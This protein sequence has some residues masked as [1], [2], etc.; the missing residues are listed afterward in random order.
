MKKIEYL[1]LLLL[2]TSTDTILFG[3]NANQLFLYVPRILGLF[4]ILTIPHYSKICR[5]TNGRLTAICAFMLGCMALSSVLNGDEIVTT[6]SKAIALLTGYSIARNVNFKT[7]ANVLYKFLVF[8]AYIALGVELVSYIFPALIG[9]MPAIENGAGTV[10]RVFFIGSLPEGF[11]SESLI[12]SN[13]IFWEAGAFASYLIWVLMIQLFY[14]RVYNIKHVVILLLALLT[15]FSTTGYFAFIVLAIA[16]MLSGHTE[17]PSYQKMKKIFSVSSI[18]ILVCMVWFG[19]DS[20]F[21]LVFGKLGD[22]EDMD[23]SAQVRFSSFFNGI[24]AFRLNPF[25]G[26]GSNTEEIMKIVMNSGNVKYGGGGLLLTNTFIANYVCFGMFFGSLFLIGSIKF[27]NFFTQKRFS[28]IF[29]SLAFL[30]AYSGERFFSFIP[31]VFMFYGF[32]YIN[33]N[34]KGSIN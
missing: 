27:I 1:L 20:I 2:F 32:T 16:Y 11:L 7:F 15:T 29:L 10:Y 34:E 30:M 5:S 8:V 28:Y 14:K 23:S 24:Q 3:T 22:G 19:G 4:A 12:R 26:G 9:V 33:E 13:G 25:F 21:D 18:I 17:E 31:F 6:L